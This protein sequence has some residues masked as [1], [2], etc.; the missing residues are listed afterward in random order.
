MVHC[1]DP[2]DGSFIWS[3]A[4][5]TGGSESTPAV[6]DD[7]IYIGSGRSSGNVNRFSCLDMTDGSTIWQRTDMPMTSHWAAPYVVDDR[8]YYSSYQQKLMCLNANTGDTIWEYTESTSSAWVSS[9]T[10]WVDPS[11]SKRVI[12]FSGALSSGGLWAIKDQGTYADLFW[13][14]PVFYCDASPVFNDGVVYVGEVYTPFRLR[15]FDCETGA[16]VFAQSLNNVAIRSAVGFAYD[17]LIVT[18]TNGVFCFE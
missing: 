12:Y 11:D 17:R 16:E 18:N 9:V 7:R 15:G 6:V 1:L 4:P 2:D 3:S 14:S 10:S 8:L 13:R 5:G